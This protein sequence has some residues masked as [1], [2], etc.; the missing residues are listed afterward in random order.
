MDILKVIDTDGQATISSIIQRAN[1][2]YERLKSYIHKLLEEGYIEEVKDSGKIYY[3]MTIRGYHL[4]EE[5]SAIK[6][7]FDKLGF[8]L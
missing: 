3:R 5:L 4:M 6:R 1:I 2:P 8:P 7:I